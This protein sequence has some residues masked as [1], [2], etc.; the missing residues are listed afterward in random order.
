M[1]LNYVYARRRVALAEKGDKTLRGWQTVLCGA[2]VCHKP[3]SPHSTSTLK[4]DCTL[5]SCCVSETALA[6]FHINSKGRLYSVELLQTVLCGAAVCQKPL[7]PHSTSTLK[8]DC[9]LWSCCVSETALATFHTNSKGRLYSVELLQTVLCGAAVCQKPLSPHSTSTLKADCTLWSCC[10]SETALATFHI[11]SKG[12]LY[13]V[14][15]LQTVLCGAAVCQKPLSPH[16][17]STLKADCTLWSCCVSETALATF[18]INSKGRLYSVE[19]LQTVLCGA[20]VCQK[21]LSPHSTSTLKADCTLWSCCVSE[22]ALATFHINSKGRL[23]SVELLQTVLCGAAVC[24]KPLS[25]HS[26]STLKAD[27]TLWSCCVSQTALATFHINSKGRLYSVELLCVTNR[28][29]HI[30]HQL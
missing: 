30:P 5:W 25:P 3:L 28:S 4:A 24:H 1:S 9:T 11:N 26:T 2:A 29:R 12:R 17:T 21:P 18:H 8:A 23:Y 6:T 10:V 20:A 7:S 22:T 27:C 14:E 15:L 16:S 13:S 19:L